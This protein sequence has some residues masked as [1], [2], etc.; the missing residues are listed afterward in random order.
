MKKILI[1]IL[2]KISRIIF[3]I[4]PSEFNTPR[5]NRL[6][7]KLDENLGEETFNHFK[8]HIKIYFL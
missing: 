8:E 5:K 3:W 7:I 2:R 1:F 6:E 4:T